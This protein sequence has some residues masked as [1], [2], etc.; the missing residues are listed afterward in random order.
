MVCCTNDL[1]RIAIV[2]TNPV[3]GRIRANISGAL[4]LMENADADLYVL[5]E[6]C[7]TGYN[8]TDAAEAAHFAE[9]AD[10]NASGKF[11]QFARSRGCHIVYGFAEKADA[12]YNSA[13][14]LGPD[15]ILG[16]YRKMH[17]FY[18]ER[19]CFT[20][21]NLGLPVFDLPFGRIGIMICFDWI[22]PEAARTLA[23]GGAQCIVHPSNLVTP[24]CPDAMVTRALENRIFTATANRVGRENRGGIDLKFIGTSELVSP[25][26]RILIRLGATETGISVAEV[27]LAEASDKKFNDLNDLL[28]DRRP[29]QY[30]L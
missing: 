9:P 14:L 4:A 19:L 30:K 25:R 22:F 15:G 27:E 18:R 21:G 11:R 13:L 24:Y 10:G 8:F 28:A 6:L 23:L 17:L 12:V 16:C 20:P 2:Q 1:M 29:D 5:P 3:F 7:T 26:G